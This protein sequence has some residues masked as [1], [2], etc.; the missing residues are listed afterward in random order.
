ME[1]AVNSQK[2][3]LKYGGMR[4]TLDFRKLTVV[5]ENAGR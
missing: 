5:D 4:R 2:L 3:V 1:S